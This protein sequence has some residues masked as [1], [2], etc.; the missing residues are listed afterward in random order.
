LQGISK[1]LD[2]PI[3]IQ[4]VYDNAN[5]KYIKAVSEQ[6]LDLEVQKACKKS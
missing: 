6:P 4:P 1:Q 2:F 5:A 3:Q